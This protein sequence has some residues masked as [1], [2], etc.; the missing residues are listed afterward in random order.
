M[1]N[2]EWKADN[3]EETIDFA[4]RIGLL[5]EAGDVITLEGDLGAGKTTFTKGI[6]KGLGVTKTVNSPTFTII[7]E[8]KGNLPLYHMDVYRLKDS[9]EDLGFDE[10]FE[11]DGITVVEWAHL[12]EDQLPMELLQIQLFYNSTSGRKI[13]LTPKGSRYMQ[14][15]KEL[16]E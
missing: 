8:Y 12:I 11:G 1:D 15:C 3:A 5:L 10:Y 2:F 13:V 6:A 4:E 9:E 14:L 7:K 16:F